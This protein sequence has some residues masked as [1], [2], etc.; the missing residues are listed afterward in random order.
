MVRTFTGA[1]LTSTPDA[2]Y[3]YR[4][5]VSRAEVARVL[6]D[7]AVGID[8]PNFKNSLAHDD[9]ERRHACGKV[10]SVMHALQR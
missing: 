4:A 9:P 6:A 7:R 5:I 2:D 3:R 1:A 8:Y 10:W